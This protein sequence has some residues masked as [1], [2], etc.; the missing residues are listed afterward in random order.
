MKKRVAAGDEHIVY[1]AGEK[2]IVY[3]A[4]DEHIAYVVCF[5]LTSSLSQHVCPVI[6]SCQ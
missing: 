2:H 6:I 4:G 1:A 3:A 5:N